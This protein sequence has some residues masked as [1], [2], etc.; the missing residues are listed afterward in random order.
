MPSVLKNKLAKTLFVL[1]IISAV[2]SLLMVA[3][4][5]GTWETRISDAFYSPT[6]TLDDIVIVAIDDDSLEELGLLP[7]PRGYYAKVIDQ[8]SQSSVIGIDIIFDLETNAENDTALADSIKNGNVVLGMEYTS[9]TFINDQLYGESL[10]KPNAVL[11]TLGSEFETGFVNLY[12]DSDGV[13]RS[14][15]PHITGIEDH[16]HFSTVI[17]EEFTGIT[18]EFDRS[19]MLINFFA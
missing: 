18:P 4:F 17:V 9:F 11:G 10:L 5:L 16:D 1:L 12:Q 8:L 3:G 13:V 7:W 2:V 19:R 15:T 14:F 6:N